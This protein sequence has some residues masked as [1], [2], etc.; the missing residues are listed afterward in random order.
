MAHFFES[1]AGLNFSSRFRHS[2]E[3]WVTGWERKGKGSKETKLYRGALALGYKLVGD[4]S[5][6]APFEHLSRVIFHEGL[7]LHMKI[8]QH[9][10]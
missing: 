10:I 1:Q 9:L 8:S 5:E 4:E 7:V 2:H 6:S 3:G